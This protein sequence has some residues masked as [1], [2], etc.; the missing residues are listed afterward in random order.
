MSLAI[1][2]S[3]PNKIKNV[4]ALS[5]YINEGILTKG[6]AE[7]NF[8]HLKVYSSHGSADQMIPVEWARRTQPFLQ[9]LHIDCQYSEFP[10]GHGVAPQN[11]YEL[12]DW[13]LKHS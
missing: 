8:D 6:Y 13:L 5:G 3:Y 7:Q 2:L 10:V 1:A 12:K 4:I 11:F 9:N